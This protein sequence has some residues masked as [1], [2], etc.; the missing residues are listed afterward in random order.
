MGAQADL[1]DTV[2]LAAPEDAEDPADTV[3]PV[4]RAGLAGAAV[5]EGAAVQADAEVPAD[6]ALPTVTTTLPH[7][8]SQTADPDVTN[9]PR[10]EAA[11]PKILIAGTIGK[12]RSHD[13]SERGI[14]R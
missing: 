6:A 12:T 7:S 3:V 8:G 10:T 13:E 14:E 1:V 5:R 2:A 4:D 11:S 9:G